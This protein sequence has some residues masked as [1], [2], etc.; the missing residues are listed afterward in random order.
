MQNVVFKFMTKIKIA[1]WNI[2]S[3]RLRIDSVIQFLKTSNIDIICLQEIKCQNDEF[4]KSAFE[5]LGFNFFDI[6]GQKGWH[7]VA[8]ASKIPIFSV[9]KPDFCQHSH[10]RISAIK[11]GEN[12]PHIHNLYVPAGGDEPDP[13]INDKF[14]HKL[15]FLER[16]DKYYQTQNTPLII[17]GDL[18][19][20]PHIN[21]VWSHKSLLKVVSHTPIETEKLE[22]LRGRGNFVDIARHKHND[23]EKL[24]SWWSYRSPD[25]QKN[26]RGRRLDHIWA[27]KSIIGK[28]DIE[29]FEIHSKTR[30]WEKPS[31]H[32]PISIEIEI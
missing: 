31:D 19:I 4:P 12:G 20:A 1:T 27:S 5:E 16:M 30:S 24:Y 22:A 6:N 7:G 8:I 10:S 11:I 29:S 9:E 3:V 32:V 15:D 13:Q 18:N 17:V 23:D 28:I 14:A 26:N 2:N 25:W 21:D